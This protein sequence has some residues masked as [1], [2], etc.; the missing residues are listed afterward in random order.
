M[1]VAFSCPCVRA[2]PCPPVCVRARPPAE[3]IFRSFGHALSTYYFVLFSSDHIQ[4]RVESRDYSSWSHLVMY[5]AI[6]MAISQTA[7]FSEVQNVQ[8]LSLDL[9]IWL[10]HVC[11][12]FLSV[13]VRLPLPPCVCARSPP[14]RTYISLIWTCII[15]TY[16]FV[17][18]SS[19]H[20]QDRVESR[21]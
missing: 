16:Y 1:C 2:C 3:H 9:R 5:L 10:P 6:S 17:L 11:C 21:D 12:F 4:D 18:F 14:C 13:C 7:T 20:I 8:I 19:D 15:S